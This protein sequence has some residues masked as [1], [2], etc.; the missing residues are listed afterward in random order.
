MILVRVKL[1]NNDVIEGSIDARSR[2]AGKSIRGMPVRHFVYEHEWRIVAE[3]NG[4]GALVGRCVCA[5]SPKVL[6]K[7]SMPPEGR[8]DRDARQT[9]NEVASPVPVAQ[10]GKRC[11]REI[12]KS[13]TNFQ[14]VQLS[15]LPTRT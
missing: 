15:A 4:A 2:R 14:I 7:R 13:G 6:D 5:T 3:Q 1:P 9:I 11:L 8:R 12:R 10:R